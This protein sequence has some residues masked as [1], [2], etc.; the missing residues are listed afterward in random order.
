MADELISREVAMLEVE[1]RYRDYRQRSE[2]SIGDGYVEVDRDL[3]MA[4]VAM[5]GILDFMH[6]VPSVDAVEVVRCGEC[7]NCRNKTTGRLH[8]AF[9]GKWG[10]VVRQTD[11]CSYGERK[12]D[13]EMP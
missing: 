5:K 4:A 13:N 12:E 1:R 3:M 2:K 10:N 8:L 6:D 7:K 9:C 11:F